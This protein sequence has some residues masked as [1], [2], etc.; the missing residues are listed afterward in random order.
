V[1]WDTVVADNRRRRAGNAAAH[2]V[3]PPGPFLESLNEASNAGRAA[4]YLEA[5]QSLTR[6]GAPAP[7][8]TLLEQFARRGT[9][10]SSPRPCRSLGRR[11]GAGAT[12]PAVRGD[13][14]EPMPV[15]WPP[16]QARACGS[17]DP[18]TGPAARRDPPIERQ[19]R[20]DE[21]VI[22]RALRGNDLSA[23]S[24]RR[25]AAPRQVSLAAPKASAV[26]VGVSTAHDGP[27]A[28]WPAAYAEARGG[29]SKAS[30]SREESSRSADLSPAELSDPRTPTMSRPRPGFRGGAPGSSGR[31]PSIE[32]AS[33]VATPAGVRSGRT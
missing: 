21:L 24:A 11:D 12:A 31:G 18:R 8:A 15:R 4:A 33:L 6:R 20:H 28:W 16:T 23:R 22:V 26:R 25:L 7:G 5:R 9:T 13:R 1:L 27:S 3:R 30:A 2:A 19:P 29:R 32:T 10:L 17:A 14:G